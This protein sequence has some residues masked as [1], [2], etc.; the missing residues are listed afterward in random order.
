VDPAQHREK[1]R[2]C[3]SVRLDKA[4]QERVLE[5]LARLEELSPGELA[6]LI[7]LLA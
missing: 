7:T 3:L 2:D 4:R 6:E 5:S 1:V